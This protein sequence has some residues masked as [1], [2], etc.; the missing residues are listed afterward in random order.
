MAPGK[1]GNDDMN[2][3]SKKNLVWLCIFVVVAG[4]AVFYLHNRSI[5]QKNRER[6]DKIN[7]IHKEIDARARV[8]SATLAC[9]R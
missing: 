9:S 6:I 7:A 2:I 3:K 8:S 1:S 4:W 5:S